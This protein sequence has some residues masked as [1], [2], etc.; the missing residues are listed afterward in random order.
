MTGTCHLSW[1]NSV[2]QT[3]PSNPLTV[4]AV[5]FGDMMIAYTA[6]PSG[7]AADGTG[8]PQAPWTMYA[9]NLNASKGAIGSLL[10]S[11]TVYT[12]NRKPNYLIQRS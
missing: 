4:G 6:L 7:F 3:F 9:I 2:P 8:Q 5:N 12:A 1:L 11:K 10:W